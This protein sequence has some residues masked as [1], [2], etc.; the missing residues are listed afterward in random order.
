[1]LVFSS[2]RCDS[3]LPRRPGK[4]TSFLSARLSLPFWS[5]QTPAYIPLSPRTPK[6]KPSRPEPPK[7]AKQPPP[8]APKA[9]TPSTADMSHHPGTPRSLTFAPTLGSIPEVFEYDSLDAQFGSASLNDAP[10][11]PEAFLP[12]ASSM[13]PPTLT[14]ATSW[15]A[16]IQSPSRRVASPFAVSKALRKILEADRARRRRIM[17]VYLKAIV[18]LK[19]LWRANERYGNV[20]VTT[21][22]YMQ[23]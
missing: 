22:M 15:P 7:R 17:K 8:K 9:P 16:I 20:M 18:F 6:R 13:S 12:E 3:L 21:G 5:T 1:M 10:E 4:Q 23:R 19:Y 14:R 2:P 11:T